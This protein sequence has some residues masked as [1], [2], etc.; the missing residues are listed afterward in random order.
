METDDYNKIY[1]SIMTKSEP[2]VYQTINKQKQ[3]LTVC[4]SRRMDNEMKC[5]VTKKNVTLKTFTLES[6][7]LS[8]INV[9]FSI[10]NEL[11]F[12]LNR[13]CL[14][15]IVPNYT[16]DDMCLSCFKMRLDKTECDSECAICLDKNNVHSLELLCGHTFHKECLSKTKTTECETHFHI[17]CSLCRANNKLKNNVTLYTSERGI[18]CVESV[19][20]DEE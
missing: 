5:I 13:Y 3:L 19:S 20:S 12:C 14:N 18:M 11:T 7:Y 6:K 15:P 1:E 17:T 4:L 8:N 16:V 10:I 2:F 9:I